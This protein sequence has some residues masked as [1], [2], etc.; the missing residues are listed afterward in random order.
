MGYVQVLHQTVEDFVTDPKFKRLVLGDQARIT[1]ENGNA[2]LAKYYFAADG[3]MGHKL[4]RRKERDAVYMHAAEQTSGR[5]MKTFLDSVPHHVFQTLHELPF[6][7]GITTPLKYAV[8]FSLHLYIIESLDVD[9]L[10]YQATLNQQLR[11]SWIEDIPRIG[12]RQ[13]LGEFCALV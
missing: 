11:F 8:S 4:Y 6:D 10:S 12:I 9:I 13:D 2:F 7:L 3:L 1:V 5:S